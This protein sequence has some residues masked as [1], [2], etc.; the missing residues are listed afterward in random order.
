MNLEILSIKTFGRVKFEGMISKLRIKI[1]ME[2]YLNGRDWE[3]N[4]KG[5]VTR[6]VMASH[7]YFI[8]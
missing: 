4:H 7:N 8:F 2:I 6:V 3:C 1:L 5:V